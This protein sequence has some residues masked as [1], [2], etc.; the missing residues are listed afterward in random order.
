MKDTAVG[1][2]QQKIGG[3]LPDGPSGKAVDQAIERCRQYL[4]DNQYDEG[5]WWGELESNVTITS[6]YLLLT[7]FLGVADKERWAQI[8]EYLKRKQRP[9][10]TWPIYYG[11]PSDLNATVEAYFAMKLA[12]VSSDKPFMVKARE[13]ILS[14][15][16]V[17]KVRNF[18]KIW[19]SLFGQWD[20]D[21]T[22]V[23]PPEIMLLPPSFPFNIYEFAS[24]ARATIVAMLVILNKR[25]VHPIPDYARIDELF[26]PDCGPLSYTV[27]GEPAPFSWQRA[28]IGLDKVL[29]LWERI[30]FKPGR[31]KALELAERWIVEHQEA[32]GSWGGIQPPWVYSLMALKCLGYSMDH[33]I[34]AKGFKGF[35]GFAI[36]EDGTFRTQ[37]CLSPVWDAAW[38]VIALRESGLPAD[39]PSLVKAGEWLLGEQITVEGDWCIKCPDVVPGGWAFEFE[40]DLYPDTDDAAEVIIALRQVDLPQEEKERAIRLGVDW[41]LGMQSGNGG[42]GSFDKDNVKRF[43]TKIP[44]CDFGEVIDPPSEDVTAHIL[45]LLGMLG[46]RPSSSPVVAHGLDYLKR[47][48]ESDGSWFGRWGVNYIYGLGAVL[49]ALR[50]IGEDMGQPYIQ[51]AVQWLKDYQQPD[52]GWGETC[53]TYDDPSLRGQGPSTASQTA[54]ALLGLLAA[55]EAHS[56]EV[57]RGVRYLVE[58][59]AEDGAWEE[60]GFTGTGFP[61]D[62]LIKYHMYRIYFPLLALGRYRR[63]VL[64]EGS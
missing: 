15:G 8:V 29:R 21:A 16:G 7:H 40:N 50:E 4:L 26:P 11:G 17:P 53:I 51:R 60:E 52:G 46:Y 44:F 19:L 41:L 45:E 55:G 62:F 54:W 30:P 6:E 2:G 48:Q 34:M 49:P 59:Q 18:T 61:R 31:E 57:E 23:M 1:K 39:H 63:T 22:P 9:D 58:H 24:W 32:D 38:A 5:Y 35:E 42:W 20:W 36:Q 3:K 64:E 33:P 27:R 25:P 12:G 14:R 43:V 13:F 37:S 10:G 28:F 47:E 56:P